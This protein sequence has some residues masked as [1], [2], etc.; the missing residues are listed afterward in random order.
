MGSHRREA[1]SPRGP[2]ERPWDPLE[3]PSGT[4]GVCLWTTS[5]PLSNGAWA[6]TRTYPIIAHRKSHR[7]RPSRVAWHIPPLLSSER[8][9]EGRTQSQGDP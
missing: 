2:I 8:K 1:P 5:Q 3:K 7:S 4:F 6:S 9:R